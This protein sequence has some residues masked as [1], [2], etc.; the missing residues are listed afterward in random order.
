MP[1]RIV[2]GEDGNGAAD[3][4]AIMAEIGKGCA[5]EHDA[6]PIVAGKDDRPLH[7]A[8]GQHHLARLQAP[9]ALAQRRRL[10]SRQPLACRQDIAVVIAPDGGPP[11]KPDIVEP[12]DLADS[13]GEPAGNV[14]AVDRRG[15]EPR[16]AAEIG[17]FVGDDHP[18]AAARRNKGCRQP[19]RAAADDQHVAKAVRMLVAVGIGLPRR[20]AH[21][22]GAADDRLI[23]HP[24]A[25]KRPDKGLVVEAGGEKR[26]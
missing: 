24:G 14:G 1:R 16:G 21:A 26:R 8:G 3:G 4:D 25:G 6:G 20:R 17:I 2:V 7:R 19:G 9:V 5:G 12:G 22:G 11:Q 13:R 10:L 23:E 18:R 15:I